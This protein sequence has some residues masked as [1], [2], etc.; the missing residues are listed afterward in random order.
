MANPL[1]TV[2]ILSM[3]PPQRVLDELAAQTYK[4]FEILIAKEK[5]IVYAMNEAVK[6]AKGEI[7]VR[8]DDDVAL[9]KK[10]LEEL[11]KPFGDTNIA[12]ATGPTF[13]PKDRRKNRDSIRFWEN[14]HW[15]LKWLTDGCKFNPSGIY[16]C[17][18]VTYDSNYQERFD[19]PFHAYVFDYN[20]KP[21]RLEG[22]NWAMRTELIRKVG[23]FDDAFDGVCEWYDNDVEAKIKKLGYKL[24]YNP[25]AYMYHLLE[26]G[27]HFN[28]RFEGWG[29]I[30][31]FLRFHWRHG[32]WR[33]LN[34]KFYLFLMVWMGYFVC[35]R[36]QR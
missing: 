32:R 19:S 4:N 8:C 28:D 7:F 5:G 16:R 31:N 23:G 22:T 35:K 34:L 33:F 13:I 1:V 17:G 20:F 6:R 15:F 18:S 14:P 29:R 36:F 25:K 30:K 10:W 12:G 21:D 9:P 26:K 24:A 11:I 2:C 3:N 27:G